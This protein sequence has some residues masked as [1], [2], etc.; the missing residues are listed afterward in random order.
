[1]YSLQESGA[2]LGEGGTIELCLCGSVLTVP[3]YT[4]QTWL[5]Q[6]V[7]TAAFASGGR[8]LCK[9]EM[10]P[11]FIIISVINECFKHRGK[12]KRNDCKIMIYVLISNCVFLLIQRWIHRVRWLCSFSA[13]G[14]KHSCWSRRPAVDWVN[15]FVICSHVDSQLCTLLIHFSF[16]CSGWGRIPGYFTWCH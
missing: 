6:P 2:G 1:M 10:W 9:S 14:S 8:D 12:M 11:I 3:C 15:I 4:E 16:L 5:P 7:H 13:S